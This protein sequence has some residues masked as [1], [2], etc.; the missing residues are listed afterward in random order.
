MGLLC[1]VDALVL[2]LHDP[3]VWTIAAVI[4]AAMAIRLYRGRGHRRQNNDADNNR[5]QQEVIHHVWIHRDDD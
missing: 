1:G 5:N 3:L 4:V 2:A